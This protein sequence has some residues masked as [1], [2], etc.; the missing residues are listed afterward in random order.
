MSKSLDIQLPE[1]ALEALLRRAKLSGDAHAVVD[2]LEF[3]RPMLERLSHRKVARH[4]YGKV[5]PSE[6]TQV[7]IIHASQKFDEFRGQTVEQFRSWLCVILEHALTDQT[8]RFLADCR[9]TTRETSLSMDIEQSS[10]ERPS[11]ICSAREQVMRLINVLEQMPS[12]LR[13][14]VR[15]R[16]QQDL[17]FTEIAAYLGL[18]TTTVRRRWMIAVEYIERAMV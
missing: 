17:A 15:M 3:Y 1:T 9:D 12:D 10:S 14:I 5:S 11:Q 13:T 2:L 6:V 8:R 4:L 18:S 7:T 16:Y